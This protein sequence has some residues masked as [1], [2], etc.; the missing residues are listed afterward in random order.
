MRFVVKY[1]TSFFPLRPL[2]LRASARGLSNMQTYM[3]HLGR[4]GTSMN[5]GTGGVNVSLDNIISAMQSAQVWNVNNKIDNYYKDNNEMDLRV[6]MRA[7]YGFGDDDQLAQLR[8]ILDGNVEIRMGADGEIAAETLIE[9]GMRIIEIMEYG[10][11]LSREEQLRLA[12][13]LGH[14][15]YRDGYAT[16]DFNELKDASIA[17]ILM[18]DRIN[19]DYNWF[20]ALNDDFAFESYLLSMSKETGN[21]TLFDDYLQIVYDYSRDYFFQVTRTGGNFQNIDPYRDIPLFNAKTMDRIN[22]INEERRQE[23]Y[24]RYKIDPNLTE[25]EKLNLM[26]YEDFKTSK[27]HLMRYEYKEMEFESLY[28]VGCRF[29][30]AKYGLE[31][32]TGIVL[33]TL[34]LHNYVTENNLFSNESDLSSKNMADIMTQLSYGLYTV[35]VDDNSG[36]PSIEALNEL[37]QSSEMY[38]ACIKVKSE[39]GN[40][41]FVM[42]SSIDFDYDSEGNVQ[43]ITNVHVANPWDEEN[44]TGTQSYKWLDIERWDIFKVT[45]NNLTS[46][47]SLYLRGM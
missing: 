3:V 46:D 10:D 27:M 36:K 28:L 21:Y 8:D 12:A 26:L 31:A 5:F 47:S 39:Y 7:Q 9:Y 4:D 22:E 38:L 17:R 23:A 35:I 11:G 29:M 44:Y 16:G 41:H 45:P 32:L 43:W 15:A 30:S 24:E 18:G 37:A 34:T 19:Q 6:A 20:Y 14:E 33:D 40:V 13:I 2:R 42:V 1:L 25:E